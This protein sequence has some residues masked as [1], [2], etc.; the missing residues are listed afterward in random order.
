[1]LKWNCSR[2]D[3]KIRSVFLKPSPRKT[4]TFDFKV[5]SEAQLVKHKDLNPGSHLRFHSQ[6]NQRNYITR[7]IKTALSIMFAKS[8]I[9]K[10][11]MSSRI[12][13]PITVR[14]LSHLRIKEHGMSERQLFAK[15]GFPLLVAAV[16]FLNFEFNVVDGRYSG[17]HNGKHE[18]H[19]HGV[20]EST[21]GLHAGE[22]Y[23]GNYKNGKRDGMGKLKYANGD[24]YEGELNEIMCWI[25]HC[26]FKMELLSS[27][28][29]IVIFGIYFL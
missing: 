5:Q 12:Q 22:I 7:I 9:L 19:G 23:D 21:R 25:T 26:L 18:R 13:L 3:L 20:Y 4:S 15:F 1:M 29:T 17:E 14:N 16:F 8:L 11:V 10:K 28:C 27:L 6:I 2:I 24:V